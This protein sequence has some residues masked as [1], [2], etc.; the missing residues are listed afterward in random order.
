MEYINFFLAMFF[1]ACYVGVMVSY[2]IKDRDA[3]RA[4]PV[5]IVITML[6]IIFWTLTFYLHHHH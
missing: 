4:D 1:T 3:T 2:I 5:G 6:M